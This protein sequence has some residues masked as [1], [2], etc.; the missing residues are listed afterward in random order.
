M[1]FL[2]ILSIKQYPTWLFSMKKK[3]MTCEPH[4]IHTKLQNLAWLSSKLFSLDSVNILAWLR[5]KQLATFQHCPNLAMTN[6]WLSHCKSQPKQT[7]TPSA[8][9]RPKCYWSPTRYA[10][11][12]TCMLGIILVVAT[13][14]YSME[15][16]I[17][18]RRF[19]LCKT[20]N[21]NSI[22]LL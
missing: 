1:V 9:T 6:I 19:F 3:I 15:T 17:Q 11:I 4:V 18:G 5:T 20:N 2:V 12:S 22:W 21:I 10:I 14:L 13:Y 8:R 16:S 7:L